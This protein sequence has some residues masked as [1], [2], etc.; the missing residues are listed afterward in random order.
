[1]ADRDVDRV[2]GEEPDNNPGRSSRPG[3]NIRS[4]QITVYK[5]LEEDEDYYLYEDSL[6]PETQEQEYLTRAWGQNIEDTLSTKATQEAVIDVKKDITKI[7][8]DII[9]NY[10]TKEEVT[11]I[12]S[13]ITEDI[14][15]NYTTFDKF[16]Q[17]EISII[18][19]KDFALTGKLQASYHQ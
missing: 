12:T 19:Q 15:N 8:Q 2:S 17:G 3:S 16:L 9:D 5:Y 10:S 1:M 7:E 13:G 11:E 4:K 18:L 14:T 6:S